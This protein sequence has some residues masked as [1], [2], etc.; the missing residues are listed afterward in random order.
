VKYAFIEAQRHQHSVYSLCC[1]LNVSRSGFYHW[2]ARPESRHKQ[3]DQHLIQH[4]MDLHYRHY[5]AYGTL[6]IWKALSQAHV[7]CGRDRVARLRRAANIETKRRKRFKVTTHSKYTLWIAPNLLNRQFI[8][9]KPNTVWVGDVTFIPTRE[10]WLYL[11]VM[12][13]LFSRKVVGWSMSDRNNVNLV[14]AA[15]QMAIDARK[16]TKGLIHHT[17]RGSLY[18]AHSYRAMQEKYGVIPS[19]SRKGDCYDNAV[20]ESFFASLKNE[21]V[22]FKHYSTRQDAKSDIFRYIEIFYNRQ[23]L[24]QTLGYETPIQRDESVA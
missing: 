6:K 22:N 7:V 13:D 17:D 23:R 4:I 3:D 11:A 9:N 10:G 14:S 16:P 24:H 21:W 2:L 18:A 5:E 19:M 20:A 1:H 8:V 12:I 15:L